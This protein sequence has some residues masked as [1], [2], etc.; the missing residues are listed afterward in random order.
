[1]I[2]LS[3]LMSI[4][5]TAL[6]CIFFPI[7][8]MIYWK[9]KTKTSLK[10]YLLGAMMFIIAV[11][12]L[13][14]ALHSIVMTTFD[15]ISKSSIWIVLYGCLSA[16]VFEEGARFVAFRYLLK[17]DN[18]GENAVAYGIGHGGIE[19]IMVVGLSILSVLMLAI[20]INHLGL[21]EIY[22]T[23][24]A[25][26]AQSFTEMLNVIQNYG[27]SDAM[28][29]ILERI[30]AMSVHICC[31]Y[32]MF[33][34]VRDHRAE[35]LLLAFGFHFLVNLPA[36]LMQISVLNNIWISEFIIFFIAFLC[37]IVTYKIYS[38]EKKK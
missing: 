1:M 31:S 29:G 4:G 15:W 35:L 8:L 16:G 38:L 27:F 25:N 10:P 23:L 36:G 12:I 13:E 33:L 11:V 34:S 7:G 28:A 5:L 2:E 19:T 32:L 14:N 6:F 20:S 3:S 9:I 37:G 18:T 21:D 30:S 24:D 17:K 22:D 26:T